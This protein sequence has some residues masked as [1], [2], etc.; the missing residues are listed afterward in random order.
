M[1]SLGKTVA[2]ITL[3][4]VLT[5]ALGFLFRIYLS[6]TIG[7]EAIGL[8][9]VSQSFFMILITIVSSGL[10]LIISR[11]TASLR[12]K[13]DKKSI[14]QLVTSGLILSIVV[15]VFL[16]GIVLLLKNVIG[17]LFT[18][19]ACIMLLI[20]LL[21]GVIFS[22]IY[23]VFR[24]ALWG[25]DN[26]FALCLSELFEQVVRII[27]FVLILGSAFSVVSSAVSLAMSMT[28]AC[29]C[30]AVFVG[31][32]FFV[33][34]GKLGKPTKSIFVLMKKAAPITGVRLLGSLA[35]PLLAV[36]IPLRLVVAGFTES[37]AM[38]LYGTMV[39][40]TYPLLF[41]PSALIGSL[42]TALIPDIAM[43][44]E[45]K[46][47]KYIEERVQSSLFFTLFIS[48]LVVP[49]YVSLGE[50]IGLF[51]YDNLLS[52]SLLAMSAWVMVPI[53]ITNITSALLNSVGLE[54][55]SFVNY[56][57]GAIGMFFAVW[58][59]P[60]LMGVNA[61]AYGMGI[62][63]VV[64]SILNCKMLRKKLGI[65]I[66]LAKLIFK[67]CVICLFV[68]ALVSFLS[69]LLSLCIPNILV[70]A[71]SGIVSV[72]AFVLLCE[73]L[74][75]FHVKSYFLIIKSKVFKKKAQKLS[76]T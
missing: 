76:K 30:S 8:Y 67:L 43:A 16:C 42:A 46:D 34:K 10:P 23:S 54:V 75:V 19:E 21:P 5:R 7:A 17:A 32:L 60:S 56:F 29:L 51:F 44:K 70:L 52:G 41:I 18:D 12:V 62:C 11:M 72:G 26:Y 63:T 48:F 66:N 68:T 31:V 61:F 47:T 50:N 64:T 55:R 45:K 36:I 37:Q 33:Y 20:V 69:S 28:L 53:G 35:M 57:V 6:R 65:K 1:K 38:T 15:S 14:S 3:F 73:V 27:I 59:L 9:Q 2:L 40:M 71:I 74:D 49:I 22:A 13:K 4:S 25:Q 58:F 39:G 24:G